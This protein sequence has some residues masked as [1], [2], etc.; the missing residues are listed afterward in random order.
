VTDTDLIGAGEAFG[1]GAAVVVA[2]VAD[3]G[4]PA[5]TRGWG[6]RYD[7]ETQ[8]L[9][10]TITAP[11]GSPTLANLEANGAISVTASQP[12]SY[13]TAQVKGVVE[14]VSAPTERDRRRAHEH[15]AAF[16]SDVA[17]L[18]ITSGAGNLF[19][20]DLRTVS[21]VVREMYDQTPG[22]NAGQVV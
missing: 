22:A 5:L 15:L 12:L 14:D 20:G 6:P 21:F 19:L 18:G 3:D 17:E 8:E 9:T 10:L 2:T 1:G 11:S 16:V 7:S 4:R 13:R